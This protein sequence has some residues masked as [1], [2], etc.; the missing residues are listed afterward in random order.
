M[1]S[2]CI[3]AKKIKERR[4]SPEEAEW[5]KLEESVGTKWCLGT[6]EDNGE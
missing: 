2:H 6:L 3:S 5:R 4:S 1:T